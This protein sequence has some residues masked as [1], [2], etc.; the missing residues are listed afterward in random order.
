[1]MIQFFVIN[2]KALL[3]TSM[4]YTC[5]LTEKKIYLFCI[6]K[7]VALQQFCI[8]VNRT[9]VAGLKYTYCVWLVYKILPYSSQAVLY[10]YRTAQ[11]QPSTVCSETTHISW[12]CQEG[13]FVVT[14]FS[15][16]RKDFQIMLQLIL[17]HV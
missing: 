15:Y 10:R 12:S 11:T 16:F 14:F 1:M 13:G 4:Q 7:N 3:D 8:I 5:T 17:D 2:R 6:N 9:F